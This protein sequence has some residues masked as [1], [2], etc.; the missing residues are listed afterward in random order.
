MRFQHSTTAMAAALIAL[1]FPAFAQ[2]GGTPAPSTPAPTPATEQPGA[3][4]DASGQA[5]GPTREMIRQMVEKAVRE[6]MQQDRGS[7]EN[8]RDEEDSYNDQGGRNED[9]DRP[10]E[11]NRHDRWQNPDDRRPGRR[12]AGHR[13]RQMMRGVGMR[14]M[15]GL[16]DTN[17][18]GSLS[19]GEVQGAVGRIFS[20]IDENDDGKIDLDETRS[21]M[22]GSSV[23]R[24]EDMP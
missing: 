22:Q 19:E 2:T 9:A 6:R 13:H 18:D 11:A 12:M 3:R 15:F 5:D 16:L 17:G 4:P 20:S 10:D 7:E 24:S 14:L 21:F 23:R 8:Y 1:T